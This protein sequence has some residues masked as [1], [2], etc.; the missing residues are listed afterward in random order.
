MSWKCACWDWLLLM[1]QVFLVVCLTAPA[2]SAKLKSRKPVWEIDLEAFQTGDV[3][4][5]KG[6]GMAGRVVGV[7]DGGFPYTHAGILVRLKGIPC[8]VH[9]VPGEYPGGPDLVKV[10]PLSIF[11]A[12]DRASAA[13]LYRL[14][15]AKPGQAEAAARAAMEFVWRH[16]PF[17]ADFDL[18]TEDKLYCTE[19]VLRAFQAAGVDLPGGRKEQFKVP[20]NK[21]GY[22]LPS[23]LLSGGHLR[24]VVEIHPTYKESV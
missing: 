15:A 21:G 10:D 13:A 20:F 14:S 2:Y 1:S 12:P 6:T 3:L 22:L 17:D 4:F 5:R 7:A 9:S 24:V 18:K 8:V 11:L 16:V 23:T 19:M